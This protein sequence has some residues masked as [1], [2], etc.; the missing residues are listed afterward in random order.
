MDSNRL[1]KNFSKKILKQLFIAILLVLACA[2]YYA[3]FLLTFYVSNQ[4]T[5]TGIIINSGIFVL[6]IIG[7]F[8]L[9]LNLLRYSSEENALSHFVEN[10]EAL[11]KDPSESVDEQAIISKRYATLKSISTTGGEINHGALSAMLT[12]DE[13]TY[14]GLARF[15]NNILILTGVFGTIVSLSIALLGASDLIDS[16]AS[17][18]GGMGL[19]IH[20]M[21]TA[22]ST[23]ITAIV[24]YVFFG[25]FYLRLHDA[26][27]HLLSGVEQLTSI[28]LMPKFKKDPDSVANKMEG[29]IKAII[30]SSDKMIDTQEIYHSSAVTLNQVVNAQKQQIEQLTGDI[31]EIKQI[32]KDGFRLG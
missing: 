11:K 26:Q 8:N 17:D 28:Y 15:I 9:L 2:G 10:I 29:L 31:S 18:L 21:S 4:Q 13:S 22:L 23:T 16:A 24:S 6:F 14:L 3:D 19:V 20:G 27:T 12:A 32:L 1:L 5:N 25:Y 7:L 30:R